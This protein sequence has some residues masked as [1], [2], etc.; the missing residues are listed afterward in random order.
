MP[1]VSREQIEQAKR[2][3]L[4][5]YMLKN[6]AQNIIKCGRGEYKLAEHDSL[7]I[8]NGKWNWFS[9]GIGGKTALDFL[10]KVRG[11]D[12]VDA[13][14]FLAP[15]R[16]AHGRRETPQTPDLVTDAAKERRLVLPEKN[17][18]GTGAVAY[19]KNERGIDDAIIV[20]CLSKGTLYEGS[21]DFGNGRKK[22]VCVFVG[23]DG[24][25]NARYAFAR[26]MDKGDN[27]KGDA[28]GS[29]KSFGFRIESGLSFSR[30][31]A[32]TESAIDAMSVAS[33]IKANA[34]PAWEE[35][36]YLS[37]GCASPAAGIRYLKEN[38][39]IE[40]VYLCLD[41]DKAGR[42]GVKAFRLAVESDAELKERRIRI[43]DKPPAM[44]DYNEVLKA[45]RH[46]RRTKD[47]ART[48]KGV[49]R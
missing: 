41:N 45:M 17:V 24:E 34:G 23:K 28:E 14:R 39:G 6:E 49:D 26:G 3:D 19:L 40:R 42:A 33:I 25:G 29:D 18:V 48:E 36:A 32:V 8:S 44:K 4:L 43:I 30:Y 37:L 46:D 11:M 15:D 5:T 35:Y 9:R 13:V 20:E 16:E 22:P 1:G 47:A 2:M 38:P 21:Y 31:L 7:K 12:F 27:F 10:V